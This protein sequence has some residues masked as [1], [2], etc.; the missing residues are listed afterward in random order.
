M[1]NTKVMPQITRK[2]LLS[3]SLVLGLGLGAIGTQALAQKVPAPPAG[4]FATVNGQPL[5]EALLDVNIRAN[6]KEGRLDSPQLRMAIRGELVGREVLAQE[7]KKLALDQTPEAQAQLFQVQQNLLANLL[8]S[9]YNATNPVTEA[10]IEDEYQAFLKNVEGA[11]QY[12]LSIIVVPNEARAKEIVAQLRNTD[13]EKAFAAIA[14]EESIDNSSEDGGKVDWLLPEQ[15]LPAV[16]NV[17]ANLSPGKIS[18]VPIQTESGWNVI[19]VDEVR[20][21]TP[22]TLADIEDQLRRAAAQKQLAAY[23][24]GLQAEAE[25]VQ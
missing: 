2:Q 9:H 1:K 7:A 21:F 24:Q 10:Q 8:I 6:V 12:Q 18:A 15:M 22:P 20:D 17:V 14:S 13:D 3:L 16:G 4:A 19:R 11:Q 23:V 5:P 25:I